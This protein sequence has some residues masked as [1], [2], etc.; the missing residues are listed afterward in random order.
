MN[1]M[2]QKNEQRKECSQ[3]FLTTN[4]AQESASTLLCTVHKITKLYLVCDAAENGKY[5]IKDRKQKRI[6]EK[7]NK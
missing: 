2:H 5:L 3:V 6:K 1:A 7:T 4:F